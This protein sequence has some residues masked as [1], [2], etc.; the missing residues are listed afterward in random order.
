VD[1]LD[2]NQLGPFIAFIMIQNKIGG[3]IQMLKENSNIGKFG[4]GLTGIILVVS[5]LFLFTST[6]SAAK[7]PYREKYPEV[8]PIDTED[9]F[10]DYEAGS[11]I[12]VDVRSKIEYEVIHADGAVHIPISNKAFVKKVKALIAKHPDKKI[13]FYC[14]GTTCKK[15]YLATQKALKAGCK[16]V[17]AYDGGIPMWAD[18]FPEKTLLLGKP[19][20]DP[21]K[22]LIPKAEFKKKAISFEDFKA[23]ATANG[24]IVVDVRDAMQRTKSLPGLEKA[25][26]IPL[27][28]FIPNFV[29]K[30]KSQNKELFIFDQV[31][32]QVRWLE[33]YLVENGYKDYTFL[34]GGA[35]SVLK[36]QVYK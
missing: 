7:F 21:K 18:A 4:F 34:K 9:L 35:T 5:C 31:G 25:K 36:K 32:K 28:K 10:K 2:S 3:T 6:A 22:Q 29:Q 27:D 12:I 15:S 26:K 30:K 17:F 14:N 8:T 16:N 13:A 19:V 11:I 23:K 20:V 33:Y 1:A 24:G